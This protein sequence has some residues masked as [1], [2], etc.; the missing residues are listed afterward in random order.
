MHKRG[1]ARIL[2]A[3][4]VLSLAL[5]AISLASGQTQNGNIIGTVSDATGAVVPKA[6]LQLVEEQTGLKR[7]TVSAEDGAYRFALIPL[8]KYTITVE[9]AGFRKYV[10]QDVSLATN[11]TLRVDVALAVGQTTEQVTVS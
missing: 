9:H 3:A 10:N 2:P 7:M 11:Q 6:V 4:A 1:D 5:L 8:G